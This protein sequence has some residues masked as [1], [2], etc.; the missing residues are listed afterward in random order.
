MD[1][2]LYQIR[3]KKIG[4]K[5][6]MARQKVGLSIED[7]SR[8]VGIEPAE[9]SQM[10]NGILCPSLPQI[11]FIASII[12]MPLDD[13]IN[14]YALAPIPQGLETSALPKYYDIRNRM[15]GIQIKKNRIQQ[16]LSEDQLAKE[17]DVE[18]SDIESYESGQKLIP[19]P[20]LMKISEYLHLPYELQPKTETLPTEPP[21]MDKELISEPIVEQEEQVESPQSES[22][23]EPVK[24]TMPVPTEGTILPGLSDELRDF[25]NKPSNLPFLELAMK[26][27]HMDAKKL[28]DIAE[29]ILEITL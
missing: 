22:L 10:E 13:L 23:N 5:L 7:L 2:Q 17:T 15:L 4:L 18:A 8:Q 12:Q 6:T 27:S 9:L 20:V 25:I 29:S 14:T 11:Q 1:S 19:F 21:S 16:N 28:R 26:L 24:E 3:A